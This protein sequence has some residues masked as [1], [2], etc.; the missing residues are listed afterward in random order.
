VLV[1]EGRVASARA[2][3]ADVYSV[4]LVEVDRPWCVDDRH[5]SDS[6]LAVLIESPREHITDPRGQQRVPLTT[7]NGLWFEIKQGV[8]EHRRVFLFDV[9]LAYAQLAPSIIA[10]R[11]TE[12]I[13]WQKIYQL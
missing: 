10:H 2:H 3:V 11:V 8:H 1:D 7:S 5:I 9:R 12:S 6:T 4:V 13:C